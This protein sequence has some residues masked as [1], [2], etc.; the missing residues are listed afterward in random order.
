MSARMH[1]SPRGADGHFNDKHHLGE[2]ILAFQLTR[3]SVPR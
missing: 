3:G 2:A 1:L